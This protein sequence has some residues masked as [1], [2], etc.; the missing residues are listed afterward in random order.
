MLLIKKADKQ[1][2]KVVF[3]TDWI[4]IKQIDDYFF[5]HEKRCNGHI[6]AVLGWK[7]EKERPD[8]LGR[9]EICPAHQDGKQLC[10]LTGGIDEKENSWDDA[11]LNFAQE[12]LEEESGISVKKDRFVDLGTVKPS[13]AA[14][15]IVHLFSIDLPDEEPIKNPKG[16][17]SKGEKGAYC[18]WISF[19]EAIGC[20]DPLMHV[21]I[22]RL[23]QN[24]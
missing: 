9:F 4:S 22:L 8:I 12:E 17:G 24:V 18:K 16:D 19:D 3:E 15:T 5:M 20:K 11:A 7:G 23:K 2:S 10:S 21:M 1:K 6:V 14:D 13:K